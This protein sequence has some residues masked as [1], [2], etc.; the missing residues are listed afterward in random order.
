ME[1]SC[2][3]VKSNVTAL[4][5]QI[6]RIRKRPS[7]H[8]SYKSPKQQKLEKAEAAEALLITT[9]AEVSERPVPLTSDTPSSSARTKIVSMIR[10]YH[11]HKPQSTPWHRE[12]EPLNHHKTPGRQIK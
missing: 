10:E 9:E 8:L 3:E 5:V 6:V 4:F 12:V 11:N 1:V 7:T 2:K